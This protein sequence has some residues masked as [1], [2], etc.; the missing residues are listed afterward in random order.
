MVKI[1]RLVESLDSA[2][3]ERDRKLDPEYR[4]KKMGK[5]GRESNLEYDF[6]EDLRR[7]FRS[8][9]DVREFLQSDD[10]ETRPGRSA[11]TGFGFYDRKGW[12]ILDTFKGGTKSEFSKFEMYR[13]LHKGETIGHAVL[14]FPKDDPKGEPEVWTTVDLQAR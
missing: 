5:V 10:W 4:A 11:Q 13:V 2:L 9:E 1:S 3:D 14:L 8:G 12:S 7:I 6:L